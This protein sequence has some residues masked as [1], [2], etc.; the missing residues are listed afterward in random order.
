MGQKA[1]FYRYFNQKLPFFSDGWR[2][3]PAFG[4]KDHGESACGG[5]EA[6]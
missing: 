5:R 2:N 1:V 3:G 4:V 6:S